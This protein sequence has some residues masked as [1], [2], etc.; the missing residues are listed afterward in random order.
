MYLRGKWV[1]CVELEREGRADKKSLS[2]GGQHILIVIY[3]P[4]ICF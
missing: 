1:E 3:L 2:F 4:F